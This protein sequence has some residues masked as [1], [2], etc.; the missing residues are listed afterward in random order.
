MQRSGG[1]N[2]NIY[3][4]R[5]DLQRP[6]APSQKNETSGSTDSR[7]G[8]NGEP[9]SFAP[10]R[11]SNGAVRRSGSEPQRTAFPHGVCG[12]EQLRHG[13]QA[14]AAQAP[15]PADRADGRQSR[16]PALQKSA[17]APGAA[18]AGP[19]PGAAGKTQETPPDPRRAETAADDAAS[20][21]FCD[22]A[23]RD[24]RRCLPDHDHAV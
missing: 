9:L 5:K 8:F 19:G 21:G 18:T 23:G 20:D 3:D 11:T 24:R 16:P 7:Y 10:D 15:E 13:P 12:P 1:N 2:G 22:P 17:P 6:Q 4:L 14:P